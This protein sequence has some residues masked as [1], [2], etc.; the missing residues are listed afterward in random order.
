MHTK[1]KK[2]ACF[3]FFFFAFLFLSSLAIAEERE[4]IDWIAFPTFEGNSDAGFTYGAQA[5]IIDYGRLEDAFIWELRANVS[6]STLNRQHHKLFFDAPKLFDRS[7]LFL[8]FEFLKIEDA[9]WFGLSEISRSPQDTFFNFALTEPSLEI[10]VS[11][12]NKEGVF[13][14]GG[15]KARLAFTDLPQRSQLNED[16]P[17]GYD[18]DR[19]MV[20]VLSAGLNHVDN[21]FTPRS[22]VYFESYL[23]ASLAPISTFTWAGFGFNTALYF[24]LWALKDPETLSPLVFAQRFM[25]E[26]LHGDVPFSELM[27]IGGSRTFRALGGVFSQRGFAENRFAGS[28]KFLSNSE[29]RAYFPPLFGDLALGLVGFVDLSKTLS[30]PDPSPFNPSYGGGLT[31]AWKDAFLFRMDYG[32]SAEGSE[33]YVEGKHLF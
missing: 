23:K 16:K 1:V 17:L 4:G 32:L 18:G 19:A 28:S 31:V 12:Q 30:L 22:G 26:S 3:T 21:P 5:S 27:R 11:Q 6:N 15:L 9:N 10:F 24:P 8:Q 13:W 20:A 29:L 33:F 14:G 25:F 7:G 2:V